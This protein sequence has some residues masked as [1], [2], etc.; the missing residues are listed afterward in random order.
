MENLLLPSQV[1]E[2]Y[3]GITSFQLPEQLKRELG[4]PMAAHLGIKAGLYAAY[5]LQHQA[6]VF[7]ADDEC[8]QQIA[9]LQVRTYG[10]D[11]YATY[12]DQSFNGR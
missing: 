1:A 8:G 10:L 3:Q 7:I 9:C 5:T 4:K 2:Y 11:I 12:H 6:A